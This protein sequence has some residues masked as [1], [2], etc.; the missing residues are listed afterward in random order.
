MTLEIYFYPSMVWIPGGA[1]A[2]T[3]EVGHPQAQGTASC[4]ERGADHSSDRRGNG[5]HN[6]SMASGG[7]GIPLGEPLGELLGEADA[8]PNGAGRFS[9]SGKSTIFHLCKGNSFLESKDAS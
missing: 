7:A 9:F 6:P 8:V 3:R 2:S 4:G 5:A 1:L